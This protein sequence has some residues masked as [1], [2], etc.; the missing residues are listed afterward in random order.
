MPRGVVQFLP[1]LG[2]WV[3]QARENHRPAALHLISARLE[4]TNTFEE[5][6]EDHANEGLNV[7]HELAK[8]DDLRT[9]NDT[10]VHV[11]AIIDGQQRI[12]I[13][14]LLAHIYYCWESRTIRISSR[15]SSYI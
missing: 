6:L 1:I 9:A 10:R 4:G 14:F 2:Y 12:T 15:V 5:F 13:L 7:L 11:Y 8:G 3:T